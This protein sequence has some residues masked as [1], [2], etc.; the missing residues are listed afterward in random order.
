MVEKKAGSGLALDDLKRA[1]KR[2]GIDGVALLHSEKGK[3]GKPIVTN[4]AQILQKIS[5]KINLLSAN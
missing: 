1:F 4:R 2:G 3:N 5:Q